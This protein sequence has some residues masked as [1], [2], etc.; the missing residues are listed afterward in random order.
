[1]KYQTLLFE[2]K[3]YSRKYLEAKAKEEIE[4]KIYGEKLTKNNLTDKLLAKRQ[5][6]K[7][8]EEVEKLNKPD[9]DFDTPIYKQIIQNVEETIY[10]E[11]IFELLKLLDF[12]KVE[13]VRKKVE[14]SELPF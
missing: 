6:I 13:E 7:L 4:V 2:L 10:K 9:F 11:K 12:V 5:I 1:M 8:V 14:L 3:Y